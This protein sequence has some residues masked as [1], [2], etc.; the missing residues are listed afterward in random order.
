MKKVRKIT[1]ILVMVIAF[2]FV[3]VSL[4]QAGGPTKKDPIWNITQEGTDRPVK[5]EKHKPNPRFAIYDHNGDS[6][7]EFPGTCSDDLVLDKETGLVW[8]RDANLP[9][10]GP[11]PE[12]WFTWKQAI[13][14][15]HGPQ[16]ELG[17]RMGWRLPTIE[18]FSSLILRDGGY[19][20]LPI[21]H[22]FVNV[23]GPGYHSFYWSSTTVEFNEEISEMSAWVVDIGGGYTIWRPKTSRQMVWPVRGGNGYATG[24]W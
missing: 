17:G 21:G 19:P 11:S 13:C 12:D 4:A 23:D 18:E 1:T 22:P 6:D 5:W 9:D 3:L 14:Y 24:N 16:M 2:C 20:E 10:L 8:A 7:P 15:C